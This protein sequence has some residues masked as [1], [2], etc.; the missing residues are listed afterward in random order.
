MKTLAKHAYKRNIHLDCD[1]TALY[2][3]V[4]SYALVTPPMRDDVFFG[5]IQVRLVE[6]LRAEIRGKSGL[7]DGKVDPILKAL[8]EN[9]APVDLEIVPGAADAAGTGGRTGRMSSSSQVSEEGEAEVDKLLL[10]VRVLEAFAATGYTPSQN[11]TTCAERIGR[12]T[13][14]LTQS[15]KGNYVE[16]VSANVLRLAQV[17]GGD[18]TKRN[19]SSF[20]SDV[21]RREIEVF[22]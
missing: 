2:R 19:A 17:L 14:K 15:K 11:F 13:V 21:L 9:G 22:R 16:G 3:M 20:T 4:L 10:C 18:G 1:A 7:G 5:R 12:D 6:L 8:R